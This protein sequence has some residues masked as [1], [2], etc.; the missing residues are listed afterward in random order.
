MTS[1][2]PDETLENMDGILAG[3][4]AKLVD[5]LDRILPL[6]R[7]TQ[8]AAR[9][10]DGVHQDRLIEDPE[11]K[12]E[13]ILPEI[14]EAETLLH[15]VPEFGE[16]GS[17]T[18]GLENLPDAM[19]LEPTKDQDSSDPLLKV[20][21]RIVDLKETKIA[22]QIAGLDIPV[23]LDPEIEEATAALREILTD[24]A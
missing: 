10:G 21:R 12:G 13:M 19:F 14:L 20:A 2:L 18:S 7:E 22:R 1:S 3:Y 9:K 15:S 16:M 17:L 11:K 23:T 6:A 24:N 5:V 4:C 8:E